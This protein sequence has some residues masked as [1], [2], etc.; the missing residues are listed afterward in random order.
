[1]ILYDKR[2]ENK[3]EIKI[4]FL[5]DNE[6]RHKFFDRE[7]QSVYFYPNAKFSVCHVRTA[8]KCIEALSN[9]EA[10]DLVCLDHDLTESILKDLDAVRENG[11]SLFTYGD[12]SGCEVAEFINESLSKEKYPLQVVIHSW[13]KKG[14]E[15]MERLIRS[16]GIPVKYLPCPI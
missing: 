11:G 1:M 6:E 4:L 7:L 10:Y 12:G 13:N 16:V 15:K 5:D 2:L 9:H 8:K 3:S 14:A